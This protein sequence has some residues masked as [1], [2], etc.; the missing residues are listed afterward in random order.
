MVGSTS[1]GS[2]TQ[3]G[4]DNSR[5]SISQIRPAPSV[6]TT[7]QIPGTVQAIAVAVQGNQALV[8]GTTGGWESP[9]DN[10]T[11]QSDR[12]SYADA[13]G[14]YQSGRSVILGS[15][16][17]SGVSVSSAG[18]VNIVGLGANQFAISNLES[19]G[20]PAVLVVDGSN[21]RSLGVTTFTGAGAASGMAVGG[22]ILYAV[23]GRRAGEC[24]RPA[25]SPTC[26]SR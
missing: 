18:T 25:R 7:L 2:A 19:N 3:T 21:P 12:Q 22:G 14:Y 11:G 1:T 6:T 16:S 5:S 9:F 26:R 15:T 8:V 4:T 20:S 10:A 24:T 17:V 13:V 23:H